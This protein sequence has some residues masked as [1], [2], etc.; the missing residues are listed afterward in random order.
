MASSTSTGSWLKMRSVFVGGKA[1]P[2]MLRLSR[3]PD[4]M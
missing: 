3:R 4:Q 2:A 1:P